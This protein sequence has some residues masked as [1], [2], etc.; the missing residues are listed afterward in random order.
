GKAAVAHGHAMTEI[1]G[2]TTALS[3]KASAVHSH[4]AAEVNGLSTFVGNIVDTAI[5]NAGNITADVAVVE[6]QW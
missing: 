5:A 6:M 3:N 1:T 4:S 2:L